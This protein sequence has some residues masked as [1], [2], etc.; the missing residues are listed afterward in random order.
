MYHGAV[1]RPT[2]LPHPLFQPRRDPRRFVGAAASLLF[3]ATLLVLIIRG[4]V[5]AFIQTPAAGNPALPPGGGGGGGGGQGLRY[6][7]LPPLPPAAAT[8]VVQQPTVPPP[9]I[10]P[11]IPVPTVLEPTPAVVVAQADSVPA[12][13]AAT[14]VGGA[15]PGSGGGSGGGAGG[16]VGPGTGAGSGPGSGGGGGGGSG[17]EP[18]WIY[19]TLFFEKPPKDLRGQ[20]LFVTFHVLADG[21]VARVETDPVIKDGEFARRFQERAETYRFKPA[22]NADGVAVPGVSRM[23]FTLPSK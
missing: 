5:D 3:H 11:P 8:A 12:A 6:I 23:A 10:A 17:R 1:T 20:T 4:T 18:Q 22:R 7:S 15:G 21:H 14:A 13:A 19:G 9:D 16:G 2:P